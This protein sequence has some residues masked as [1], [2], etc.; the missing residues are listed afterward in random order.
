MNLCVQFPGVTYIDLIS[1]VSR[2]QFFEE[3]SLIQLCQA[4]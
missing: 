3:S 1:C 4:G 2:F